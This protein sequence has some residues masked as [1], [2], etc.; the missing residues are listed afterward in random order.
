MD[1]HVGAVL[2]RIRKAAGWRLVDLA[3]QLGV[4]LQQ[5]QKHESGEVRMSA[6]VLAAA[7]AALGVPVETFFLGLPDPT[8]AP[9]P[10]ASRTCVGRFLADPDAQAIAQTLAALPPD[11]RRGVLV[12]LRS[13]MR[14]PDDDGAD[15][16]KSPPPG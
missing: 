1:V 8:D 7:G 2:R 15:P 14:D 6:S 5:V 16:P 4:S 10:L 9:A 12:L 3:D 13:L 11:Q